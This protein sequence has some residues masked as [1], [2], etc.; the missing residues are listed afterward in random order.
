VADVRIATDGRQAREVTDEILRLL[1]DGSGDIRTVRVGLGDRSYSVSVGAGIAG[2]PGLLPSLPDAEKAFLVTHRDLESLAAPV[3]S[4]LELRGL[5]VHTLI[6]PAG[7]EGKSLEAISSLYAGLQSAGAH[8]HDLVVTFGGGVV[9]DVGGFAASTYV[10]GMRLVH[11][12]TTLLGQ[13]DAAVGGKTGINLSHGKNL[14]GTIYQ[15]TAVIC[16][17][18]SLTSCPPEEIRSGLAE[19]IKYGFIADPEL[20][21]LVAQRWGDIERLDLVLLVDL[22]A[23]CVA[24]KAAIVSEDERETGDRAWLNYGH[25]FA[26]GIE[27]LSGFTGIRHGEAVAIGMMAAAF[28]A[29]ELQRIDDDVLNLHRDILRTAGLPTGMKLDL[30]RLEQ[31]WKH[32]KKYRG[33]NRFVLL[34]GLGKPEADVLVPRPVLARALERLAEEEGT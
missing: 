16:D 12:P 15:P 17:V 34:A 1:G 24:I 13:V 22:V 18:S 9:S 26:H 6:V 4:A 28:T 21:H 30:G 20:L 32:D 27:A 14:V 3:T 19:V 11:V 5:T 10:R 8:R 25:T 23:R 7:E 2:D 29:H 33:G 31:A